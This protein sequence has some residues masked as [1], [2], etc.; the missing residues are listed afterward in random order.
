[1]N[2]EPTWIDTEVLKVLTTQ[3]CRGMSVRSIAAAIAYN[4]GKDPLS[5][6]VQCYLPRYIRYFIE[7]T[8]RRPEYYR[9]I[10]CHV[11]GSNPYYWVMYLDPVNIIMFHEGADRR[12]ESTDA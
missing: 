9:F 1:M 11:G 10:I 8:R 6:Y 3:D 12:R 4:T 2:Y 5:P 7:D